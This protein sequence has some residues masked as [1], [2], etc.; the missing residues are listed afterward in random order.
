[1]SRSHL[2]GLILHILRHACGTE[3]MFTSDA[4][5][6]LLFNSTYLFVDHPNLTKP[7]TFLSYLQNHR[8][9]VLSPLIKQTESLANNDVVAAADELG[10]FIHRCILE[11]NNQKRI[12]CQILYHFDQF[13]S[14]T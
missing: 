10:E 8:N 9:E 5:K 1:M 2:C 14:N 3:N 13:G 11:L 12:I 6:P 4:I 7:K